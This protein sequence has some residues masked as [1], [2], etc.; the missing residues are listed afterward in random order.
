MRLHAVPVVL[1]AAF[2]LSSA[3]AASP[4]CPHGRQGHDRPSQGDQSGR[5]ADMQTIHALFGRRADIKR[6]VTAIE[7]GVETL[8]ESHD[9]GIAEA[10]RQH[11]SGMYRRLKD[12]RPIHAR[13][14][15]FAELFRNAG[16][17]ELAMEATAHGLRVTE[18]SKDPYVVKL[19]RAH[20]DVVTAFLKNGHS[21]MMRT[22][23]VPPRS[24][25]R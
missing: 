7:G 4:R 5:G 15:L 22:H 1:G 13:D 17:I 19:I 24:T 25:T 16:K 20:A 8:T 18:T 10:I 14:P 3:V 12:Q 11:V 6:T 9:P 23:D 21:E 2:A